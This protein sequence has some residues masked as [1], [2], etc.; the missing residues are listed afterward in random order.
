MERSEKRTRQGWANESPSGASIECDKKQRN[1]TAAG[2]IF[3]AAPV[4]SA[5]GKELF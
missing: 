2:N 5:L 1:I 3:Y 4:L